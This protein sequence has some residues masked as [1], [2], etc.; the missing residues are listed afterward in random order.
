MST[1]SIPSMSSKLH[2]MFELAQLFKFSLGAHLFKNSMVI[3]Y[4]TGF[5]CFLEFTIAKTG[6]QKYFISYPIAK[7][8]Q[9]GSA[10]C[11]NYVPVHLY[12]N[13]SSL[14]P[15]NTTISPDRS[16]MDFRTNSIDFGPTP[17]DRVI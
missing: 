14:G 9:I 5:Q 7:S 10:H 8:F 3:W 11:L 16:Q 1:A 2:R 4:I 15:P 17:V 6:P 12:G 13:P